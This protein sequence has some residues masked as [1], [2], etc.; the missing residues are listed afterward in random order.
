M[1]ACR[2][3]Y[4][5]AGLAGFGVDMKYLALLLICVIAA[6]VWY[7]YAFVYPIPD[8]DDADDD[9]EQRLLVSDEAGRAC[10]V[11]IASCAIIAA[12]MGASEW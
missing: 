5:A 1:A 12:I 8:C 9:Q 3:R 11:V 2:G 6:L 10:G 4:F 7:Y